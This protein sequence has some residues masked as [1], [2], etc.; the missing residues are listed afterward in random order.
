MIPKTIHYCWFG[1]N[2]LPPLA[3]KCIKSWKKYCPDFEI[4]EWN[5]S[6][7]DID[8]S[9]L[10]VRQAY[11]A[12]KWAFITDYVRLYALTKYG[13]IYMDTD[14]QV[15][16]SLDRFLT[17]RAFSGFEDDANI[18]TG[19][20]ACE[21]GFPVFQEFLRYYDTASL[22]EDLSSSPPVTNVVV[23]TRIMAQKG[24][25]QNNQLQEVD[26]FVLYPKDYFCPKSYADGKIYKTRNTHT[27]H[28]FSGSW[29]T[30]EQVFWKKRRWKAERK[31][32]IRHLPLTALRKFLGDDCYYRIRTKL[33]GK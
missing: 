5:E 12:K 26:G 21:K 3:L 19:I 18:P 4:V 31:Q 30:E 23:I 14:V 17:H 10:Y 27:I 16:R 13:G 8:T 24:L 22:Y 9:P 11:E 7:F 6:N 29:Q 32:R 33:K 1:G 25:Q 28:H 15:V 2:P 20:M